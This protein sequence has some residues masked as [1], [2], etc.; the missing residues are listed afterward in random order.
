[1]NALPEVKLTVSTK[2]VKRDGKYFID[3]KIT[4]PDSSQAVAFAV[5]LQ[6]L[7]AETGKRILP[8][9]MTDN[10]FSLIKGES[11]MVRFEFDA[12]LVPSGNV[13]LLVSPYVNKIPQIINIHLS[14]K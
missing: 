9:F 1:M 7:N 13:K 2:T 8:V 4:N 11:R 10:Y 12:S 3:A 6:L 14:K 5:R